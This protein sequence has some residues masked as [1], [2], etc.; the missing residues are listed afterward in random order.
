MFGNTLHARLANHALR[1]EAT[2]KLRVAYD[3]RHMPPENV[4][5]RTY[6]VNLA[7]ALAVL[8][9]IDLTLLVRT[10]VQAEGL[11]GD[12]VTEQQWRDDVAVIHKPA[13]VFSRAELALLFGSSAHVV[14][15][16]Q[17]LI[18][19]RIPVVF[20]SDDEFEAYRATSNLSLLAAQ[21]ILAYSESSGREI[22][23]EF[24][25]P[26]EEVVVV[27]LG[28]EAEWFA[29]RE[30]G[31]VMIRRKLKLPRRY[32][33]SLATD[34]PHK[35]LSTLLDA[36]A[37]LRNRWR[38]GKPPG[39]VLAGYAIGAR[40]RLYDGM[41]PEVQENGLTYLGPVSPDELRVLYQNAEALVFPS[42]YEG[43]G[44]PPLEAMAAGTPVVAMP[45]SS[46]PEVGGDAVLYTE[47][48]SIANLA[49]A[50][51]RLA[52]SDALQAD[53]RD[54]G[55]KRAEQ[56]RWENTA[57]AVFETYR[58]AVHAPQ[59]GR[60]RPGACCARRSCTGPGQD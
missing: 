55:L 15:T 30:L 28:V 34:Y 35:N 1:F 11:E 22:S 17:D 50:M 44:L 27:P 5:T 41:E 3:I 13:Q 32:F 48:L 33:F 7:K 25:I 19:Y 42:L 60:S 18:A 6:A 10:P 24:G 37:L 9:D 26:S 43:F 4:G 58:S 49:Q 47:G 14:I 40:A 45:F 52:A 31:D 21:R 8:P 16:Y 51:E 53:L 59:N 36:Y 39:L 12:V 2:G 54:R 46:I 57:R 56:F 23:S 20:S 29:H 38:G